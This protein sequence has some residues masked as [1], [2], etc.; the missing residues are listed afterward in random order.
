MQDFNTLGEG[1]F[2]YAGDFKLDFKNGKGTLFLVNGDIFYGHFK[3]DM[4]HGVGS[5]HK[6][7]GS[8]ISGEWSESQLI[9]VF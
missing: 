2:K 9:H 1:W 4:V 6:A 8:V 7:D 3:N 5:Y